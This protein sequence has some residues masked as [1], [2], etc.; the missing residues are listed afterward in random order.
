MPAA[1]RISTLPF[2]VHRKNENE[3]LAG[4]I[5][6]IYDAVLDPA[7]WD[8][9]LPEIASFVGGQACGFL[10]KD[11]TND[12]LNV[13]HHAG[14]SPDYI[15]AYAENFSRSDPLILA[16]NYGIE[17]I[18]TLAE[19]VPF[20][21]YRESRFYREWAQ[22]Q[23]WLDVANAVL[24]RSPASCTIFSVVR[25]QGSGMVDAE[26]RRRMAMIIPHAR[27][28]ALVRN[29]IDRE[30]TEIAAFAA[31]LDGLSAGLFLVDAAGRIVHANA[32]GRGIL[33]GEDFLRSAGGRLMARDAQTQQA[34]RDVFAVAEHGSSGVGKEG[35]AL[36]LTAQ[37]G[38][39]HVA[40]VLPLSQ[41]IRR[42][43]GLGSKATAAVFVRRAALAGAF[44]AGAL[45]QAFKLTPAELRVLLAIVDVGGVPDVAA[46]LGVAE[47]TV[48]THLSRLFEKTGA[49]RQADLVKLVAGYST[50]LAH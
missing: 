47:S 1:H 8:D 6:G 31:T 23:G 38:T 49:S 25:D 35:I 10:S 17:Q 29:S 39:R 42:R 18:V 45:G 30:Q 19:L 46:A 40:H 9:V 32:A 26:L 12:F 3:I 33:S 34:L 37:D 20:D 5:G 48:K 41:D 14:V 44:P 50:P 13:E 15:R 22:P 27:R 21:E 11:T 2:S 28:A 16:A 43:A 24:D 4:L 7:A 36:P